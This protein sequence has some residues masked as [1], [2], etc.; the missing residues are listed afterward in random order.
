MGGEGGF[1]NLWEVLDLFMM[2]NDPSGEYSAKY[3]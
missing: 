3:I 2:P 1:G